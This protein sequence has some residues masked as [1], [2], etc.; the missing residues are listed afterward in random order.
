MCS[1][2]FRLVILGKQIQILD[3][4]EVTPYHLQFICHYTCAWH[5]LWGKFVPPVTHVFIALVLTYP[6]GK[7]KR[8]FYHFWAMLFVMTIPPSN[9]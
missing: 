5:L 9:C 3:G 8:L 4:Q 7:S 6:G 1:S 2:L